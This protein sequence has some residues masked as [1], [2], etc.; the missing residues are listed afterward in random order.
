M[1]GL[2]NYRYELAALLMH[3]APEAVLCPHT[4]SVPRIR[5]AD[6]IDPEAFDNGI[7]DDIPGKIV[8]CIR[9]ATLY[10]NDYIDK[11]GKAT[12]ERMFRLVYPKS[13]VVQRQVWV[14]IPS[15]NRKKKHRAI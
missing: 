4:I 7:G 11:E 12:R 6:D 5:P 1:F 8:A 3:A 9:I 2:E 14:A 15:P 10:G 13:V